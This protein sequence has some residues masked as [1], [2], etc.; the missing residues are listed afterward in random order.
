M[1]PYGFDDPINVERAKSGSE[2]PK[3]HSSDTNGWQMAWE[4][5]KLVGGVALLVWAVF[6]V[7]GTTT[8]VTRGSRSVWTVG[9]GGKK[10]YGSW[11]S[12]RH[13]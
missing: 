1:G 7:G 13:G 8:S 6:S 11:S 9:H 5:T 2:E 4:V 10:G 12:F 3:A